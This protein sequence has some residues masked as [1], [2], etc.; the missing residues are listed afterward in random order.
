[1]SAPIDVDKDR[2]DLPDIVAQNPV[3]E[4]EF[5]MKSDHNIDMNEFEMYKLKKIFAIAD[6]THVGV[7]GPKQFK[8]LM[9]MLGIEPTDEELRNMMAEMDESGDGTIDFE[10]FAVAMHHNYDDSLIEAASKTRIGGMGTKMWTRGEVIWGTN[11]NMIIIACSILTCML[12]EFKFILVPLTLAFFITF[13]LVP[14]MNLF[15]LRPFPCKGKQCCSPKEFAAREESPDGT[16][17]TCFD[18]F[19]ALKVPHGLSVILTLA[20]F[21]GAVGGSFAM[22]GSEI[23]AFMDDP[24][25][26]AKM[27]ELEKDYDNFLN[28]SGIKILAP[29]ICEIPAQCPFYATE[30]W[31][32][33]YGIT[34][35]H[36]G[37][38]HADIGVMM[39]S[40]NEM[41]SF[42]FLV[43]LFTVYLMAE[44]HPGEAMLKGD[45]AC[46][47]EINE[48][49]DHYISLKTVISFCTGA[50]VSVILLLIGIK[51]AVL[52]GLMTFMLN[53]IPNVGSMIAMFLPLPVVLLD[54]GLK[55]W[56]QIMAFAGP[57]AVQG[58]V[59]NVL[60]PVLFGKSLN[61]TPLSILSALVM[62]SSLWGLSGAVMSVPLL[63]IQK[64]CF[65]YTNHP[66]A[67]MFLMLIREDPTLDEDKERAAAGFLDNTD[68]IDSLD[69]E[70]EEG[71]DEEG[72]GDDGDDK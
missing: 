69:G 53:Y 9:V 13:L 55:Q 47:A 39:N 19:T 28:D 26:K 12:V 37:H 25:I 46:L 6:L 42:S 36:D 65:V 20:V 8:E 11:N 44:K 38:T 63:G 51:L 57:G 21:F 72:G 10:E 43:V 1:M 18:L 29:P 24:P 16:M 56:Q 54:P 70:G 32:Y 60:E 66:F 27:E 31:C 45:N 58:Y 5:D 3:F 49:I 35:K 59:G 67:K 52:F 64:I 17:T 2:K 23:A 48:M 62:W 7:I 50:A 34:C 15:E 14:I 40:L 4:L 71:G 30:K 41:V 68:A 61:M 22:V 33:K